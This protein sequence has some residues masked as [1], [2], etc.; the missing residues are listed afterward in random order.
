MAAQGGKAALSSRLQSMGFMRRAQGGQA[1]A[2]APA[3]PAAADSLRA[4]RHAAASTSCRDEQQQQQQHQQQGSS[5]QAAGNDKQQQ[6]K[7]ELSSKLTSMKF[8]QRGKSAKRG[9]DEAIGEPDAAKQEAEWVAAPAAAPAAG[10]G[11]QSSS[12]QG[13]VVIQER[14]PLPAGVFGRMSFGQFNSDTEALQEQAE[15]LAT[16]K[17]LPQAAKAGAAAAAGWGD[18]EE[19]DQQG[20]SVTDNDMAG[21]GRGSNVLTSLRMQRNQKRQRVH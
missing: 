19:G 10:P 21:W 14:D 18:E 8:M 6:K 17:P 13:C 16:G 7:Y 9:Y 11:V 5:G 15:A 20:V 2:A 1:A 3:Q 12:I 4:Q